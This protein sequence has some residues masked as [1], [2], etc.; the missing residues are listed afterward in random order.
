M[1]GKDDGLF[2]LSFRVYN[3]VGVLRDAF[4][5]KG[6]DNFFVK[7]KFTH[8]E[9]NVEDHDERA[10]DGS[11]LKGSDGNKKERHDQLDPPKGCLGGQFKLFDLNFVGKRFHDFC[12]HLGAFSLSGRTGG[13]TKRAGL[14]DKF[15]HKLQ[16]GV[17]HGYRH[18]LTLHFGFSLY[19]TIIAIACNLCQPYPAGTG[20]GTGRPGGKGSADTVLAW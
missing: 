16:V 9:E 20:A 18:F 17:G 13:S 8:G 12:G 11:H 2:D 10:Y 14:A 15:L 6:V 7:N 1:P 3:P 19:A 5:H 4:G